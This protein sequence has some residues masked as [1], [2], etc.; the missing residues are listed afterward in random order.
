MQK[1]LYI[2]ILLTNFLLMKSQ[3]C[4]TSNKIAS[5]IFYYYSEPSTRIR[6]ITITAS[7]IS[8]YQTNY[9]FLSGNHTYR[10]TLRILSIQCIK[11]KYNIIVCD[12]FQSN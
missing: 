2:I 11:K 10:N 4:T 1:I 5:L 7:I 9:Y 3:A 12:K 6:R 8:K